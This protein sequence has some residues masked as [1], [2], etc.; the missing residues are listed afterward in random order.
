MIVTRLGSHTQELPLMEH[1]RQDTDH[2]Q[3]EPWKSRLE[4][5]V[6]M[7][8]RRTHMYM[9]FLR[10]DAGQH[11][12]VER[13]DESSWTHVIQQPCGTQRPRLKHFT[14]RKI[15]KIK[16]KSGC[17]TNHKRLHSTTTPYIRR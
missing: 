12:L 4:R 10:S 6:D 5:V 2:A 3:D 7:S 14:C 8:V 11:P 1:S 13:D 15:V 9:T 17:N 16:S